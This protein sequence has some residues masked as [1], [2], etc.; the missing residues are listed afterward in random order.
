MTL[1]G[2]TAHMLGP[3]SFTAITDTMKK[4][5]PKTSTALW[6]QKQTRHL[7]LR[8]A[9]Q[10][11]SKSKR[12]SLQWSWAG[13]SWSSAKVC[14]PPRWCSES[15]RL[16][17]VQQTS[18]RQTQ[19]SS[20]WKL[21]WSRGPRVGAPKRCQLSTVRM[22]RGGQTEEDVKGNMERDRRHLS[23]KCLQRF[24][25]L[26]IYWADLN[27]LHFLFQLI[28]AWTAMCSPSFTFCP[29]RATYPNRCCFV[30]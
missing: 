30:F 27:K 14:C 17:G 5:E 15:W 2:K 18:D 3:P 10:G 13:P 1:C 4:E 8:R 9:M 28:M 20:A 29:K 19:R 12:G 24:F 11:I 26:R 16:G 21:V 22:E 25:T 6:E 23:C 7:G